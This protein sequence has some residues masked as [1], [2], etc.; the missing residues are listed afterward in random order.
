M[1]SPRRLE[2]EDR[3]RSM[4]CVLPIR[5]GEIPAHSDLIDCIEKSNFGVVIPVRRIEQ[6][7]RKL[8]TYT[9]NLPSPEFLIDDKRAELAAD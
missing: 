2:F 7:S 9:N 8:F 6:V 3:N 5:Q 4:R 1:L